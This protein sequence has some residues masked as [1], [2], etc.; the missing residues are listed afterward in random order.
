MTGDA[1]IEDEFYHVRTY[2]KKLRVR[3]L[4]FNSEHLKAAENYYVG[5]VDLMGA[6]HAMGTSVQKTANFLARLHIAIERSRKGCGF[7][8]RLLPIND[9]VFIVARSK[10]E[11]MS[12]VGRTMIML[13]ANFIAI[14]RPH[15][16]FLLRSGIAYGPVYFGDDLVPGLRPKQLREGE[17]FLDRV[18]FGPALIQAYRGEA[19]A[20]PYG[21]AIH[22]SARAFCPLGEEP[23]R[24]THWMWWAPNEDVNYPPRLP[25]LTTLKDCL[26]AELCNHFEW[27]TSS[28]IYHGLETNKI[29]QWRIACKQYFSLG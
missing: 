22:E 14:P 6:G 13:S 5:W 15:D 27:L 26:R 3:E 24:M 23:F 18:M 28:S 9:G 17:P 1:N 20:P 4:N 11:L 21:V 2:A 7:E 8:G 16:R 19:A 29:Q 12:M 10:R 25:P